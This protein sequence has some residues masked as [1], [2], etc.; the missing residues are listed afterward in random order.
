VSYRLLPAM[1]ILV[2]LQDTPPFLFHPVHNIR[3]FLFNG[4]PAP[5]VRAV[6][7]K[8]VFGYR[9]QRYGSELEV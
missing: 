9:I 1:V 6:L 8:S 2:D 3:P 7:R 5:V 4:S